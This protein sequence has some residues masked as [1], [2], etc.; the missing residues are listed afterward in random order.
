MEVCTKEIEEFYPLRRAII[1]NNNNSKDLYKTIKQNLSTNE[2]RSF[3]SICLALKYL[4]R[5]RKEN[6]SFFV[7]D[8]SLEAE[9]E[10]AFYLNDSNP[11]VKLLAKQLLECSRLAKT[12]RAFFATGAPRPFD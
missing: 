1:K 5:Y 9:Y 3:K 11:E 2:S 10:L 7:C 12:E 6:R 8:V 4:K